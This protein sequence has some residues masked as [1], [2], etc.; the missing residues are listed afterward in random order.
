[1]F[2]VS[3][4]LFCNSVILLMRVS[5]VSCLREAYRQGRD[6]RRLSRWQDC[7][8]QVL[9]RVKYAAHR[10]NAKVRKC[11]FF[12]GP[13]RHSHWRQS[14]LCLADKHATT[15]RRREGGLLHA[16][17]NGRAPQSPNRHHAPAGAPLLMGAEQQPPLLSDWLSSSD[18]Y[19]VPRHA[20]SVGRS[21]SR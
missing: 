6:F 19:G 11:V 4:F 18:G 7:P 1:M 9:H 12:G 21:C 3:F 8:L 14:A 2:F 16:A 20:E 17:E 10:M 5:D 13:K 15:P